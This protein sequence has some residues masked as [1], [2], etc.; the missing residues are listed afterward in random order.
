[1]DH[2]RDRPIQD[3]LEKYENIYTSS[4]VHTRE[5]VRDLEALEMLDEEGAEI[6]IF[7]ENGARIP[8]RLPHI[9]RG[10]EPCGLQQDLRV[11]RDMFEGTGVT[12]TLEH[13]P[14]SEEEIER[15]D[16]EDVEDM[17]GE[18]ESDDDEDVEEEEVAVCDI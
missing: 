13:D 9:T 5:L 8:R 6:P 2:W 11:T 4:D 1:M 10:A 14:R 7:D 17:D 18:D 15:E 12:P 16:M 3:L